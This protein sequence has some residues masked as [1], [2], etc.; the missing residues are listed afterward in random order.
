MTMPGEPWP[1]TAE[2]FNERGAPH[3]PGLLGMEITSIERGA[4]AGRLE[5]DQRHWA[6]N[7]FLHAATVVALADTLCGNGCL[8]SLPEG[9]SGFTTIELKSNF[10]G[11]V[12]EGVIEGT[13]RLVHGGRTT[14][15]WDAD[16]RSAATGKAIAAFRCTQLILYPQP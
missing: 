16:V 2:G 13:A 10:L 11:T 8:M 1:T 3:L 7:G 6:A 14:Q 15:V 12:R 5:V 4:V 9:A